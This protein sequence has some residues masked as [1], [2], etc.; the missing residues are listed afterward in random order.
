MS[1]LAKGTLSKM[2]ANLG[3]AVFY[4][5]PVGDAE[6]DLNPYVGHAITL[7]HTG[8]I[9]CSSCGKKTKKELLARP[10]FCVHEKVGKLRHVHNETRNL[11]LR[12]RYMS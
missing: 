4:R 1:I 9:Y 11:P 2:R 5:L 7:T 12:P 10:L 6:I 8:N 3:E